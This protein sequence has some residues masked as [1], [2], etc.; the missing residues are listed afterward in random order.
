MCEGCWRDYGAPRDISHAVLIGV[1][2]VLRV[3]A[4]NAVGGRLHAQL[5]DWN[6]DDR[7]FVE[8]SPQ[9]EDEGPAQGA[10]EEACFNHMKSLTVRERAAVLALA[11][12]YAPLP[13]EWTP[14]FPL[15]D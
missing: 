4:F 1:D 13:A 7:H 9:A 14:A 12:R 11:N 15:L 6:I 2:H 5:D 3:Y 10:A 8:I